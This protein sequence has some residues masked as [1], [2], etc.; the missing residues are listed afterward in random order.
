MYE[1]VDPAQALIFNQGSESAS[2][3]CLCSGPVGP[4]FEIKSVI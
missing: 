3:S 2:K 1:Q 4:K